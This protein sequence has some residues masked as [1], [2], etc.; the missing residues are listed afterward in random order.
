LIPLRLQGYFGFELIVDLLPYLFFQ[1]Y[2]AKSASIHLMTEIICLQGGG[3]AIIRGV[4]DK[5]RLLQFGHF[6]ARLG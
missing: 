3:L 1:L 4:D 5:G 2:R 6:K